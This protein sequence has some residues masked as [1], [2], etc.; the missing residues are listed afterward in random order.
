MF[1]FECLNGANQPYHLY[2]IWL[3]LPLMGNNWLLLTS[4]LFGNGSGNKVIFVNNKRIG[5]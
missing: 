1:Y 5:N 2:T 4:Y 3:S